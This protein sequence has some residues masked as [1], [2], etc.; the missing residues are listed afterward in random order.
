MLLYDAD[1][2]NADLF[3]ADLTNASL[4][5]VDLTNADLRDSDLTNAD[6]TKKITSVRLRFF[7]VRTLIH[8]YLILI[9]KNI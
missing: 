7:W 2:T 5:D 9:I 3:F 8:V 4:L 1:L 6:L